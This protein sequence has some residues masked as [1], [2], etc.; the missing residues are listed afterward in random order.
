MGIARNPLGFK[1]V[2]TQ[3]S[4]N[5][6]D[7]K[8][9][10]YQGASI[11]DNILFGREYDEEKY[12]AVI[13]DAS[14]QADLEMLPQGDMTEVGEKGISLSGGQKQR[15]NIARAL[16]YSA[17]V[18]CLD[19]PFSALDAHVGKAV[20]NNAIQGSLAGKTRLLV[21]HALHFR[22]LSARPAVTSDTFGL[23]I[24]LL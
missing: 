2:L 14:L 13:H 12:A 3:S 8:T 4:D 9:D 6:K 10:F 22:M 18:I 19:D 21:T 20:F 16:Y 24:W 11:R 5:Q 1:W 23:T 7:A 15:I 17:D